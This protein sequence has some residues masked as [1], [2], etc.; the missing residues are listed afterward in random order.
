[1]PPGRSTHG[2]TP[3]IEI[4]H[5][6]A[7]EAVDVLV[8]LV[9]EAERPLLGR[10]H[11]QADRVNR[12]HDEQKMLTSESRERFLSSAGRW[13]ANERVYEPHAQRAN[14]HGN[15][16]ILKYWGPLMQHHPYLSGSKNQTVSLIP[17]L[18]AVNHAWPG[19]FGLEAISTEYPHIRRALEI[20]GWFGPR[21]PG[22]EGR[23]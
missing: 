21:D 1:M 16:V 22:Q 15:L 12:E 11:S 14:K 2:W 19:G 17:Q 8:G 18:V 5:Q 9:M 23:R 6:S 10:L 3:F 7:E 4:A 13:S 20:V